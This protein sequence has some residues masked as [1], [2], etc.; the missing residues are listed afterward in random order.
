[1]VYVNVDPSGGWFDSSTATLTLPAGATVVK[2]FLY[3]AGDLSEGINRP[4]TN[5][6]S[7]AA[8]GGNSVANNKLYTTVHMRVGGGS[9]ST[10]DATNPTRNGQWAHVASWYSQPGQ[11]SR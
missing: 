4:T 9:Y 7:F 8:P 2:A 3:W 5:P 11:R 10:I 6:P 1:M